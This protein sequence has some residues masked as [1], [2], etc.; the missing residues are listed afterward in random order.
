MADFKEAVRFSE[1]AALAATEI[2]FCIPCDSEQGA[3]RP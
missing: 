2:V 3:T 1:M